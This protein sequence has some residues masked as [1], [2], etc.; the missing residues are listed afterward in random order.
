MPNLAL[1]AHTLMTSG[2]GL[3]AADES[4]ATCAKRFDALNI[5]CTE[6]TR[7]NYREMLFSTPHLSQ[8]ISGIILYDETI[9][10]QSSAGP[11]L[12]QLLHSANIIPGI[13]V[14]KGVVDL[15]NFPDEKITEGLDGLKNRVEEYYKL[16][17]RFAKW[18]AVIKITN[19]L[20]TSTAILA[21][22]EALARYSAICQSA[23]LVPIV[24]PEVLF[25]GNHSIER[26]EVVTT[27]VLKALFHDLD[28]HQIDLGGLILKSSFVIAGN[29][30]SHPSTPS[31]VAQATLRAFKAAVPHNVAGIVFLSGGQTPVQSTQNLQAIAE[32]G[33]QP[34]PITFSYSRA[35]QQP[36]LEAWAGESQNDLKAQ[37]IFLQRAHLNSLASLGKYLPEF[38]T[39]LLKS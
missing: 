11:S 1:I 20:P 6:T 35:L 8:Y 37:T 12:V 7:R 34:W 15:D 10:Q 3:F 18:R 23:G 19:S 31:E 4:A 13:K 33:S 16:G 28:L 24:E 38:E 27:E 39:D 14:D 9:R 30:S 36:A 25:D 22:T 17:A 29:N 32:L 2:K 21:N 5:P 26:A